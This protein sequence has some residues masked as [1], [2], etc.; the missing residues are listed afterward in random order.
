MRRWE[1]TLAIALAILAWAAIG[2]VAGAAG[3]SSCHIRF[4]QVVAARHSSCQTVRRVVNTWVHTRRCEI[5]DDVDAPTHSRCVVRRFTCTGRLATAPP[6]LGGS[7]ARVTCV[8]KRSRVTFFR[9][10]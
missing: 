9:P 4:T 6:P 1:S 8:H 5:G 7:A 10:I 3:R 2:G